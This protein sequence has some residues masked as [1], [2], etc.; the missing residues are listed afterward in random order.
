MPLGGTFTAFASTTPGLETILAGELAAIGAVPG[1]AEPGGIEFDA[2]PSLLARAL[3]SLRTAHRITVR[4]AT[5]HARTF[6]ELERHAATVPWTEFVAKGGAVHFRVTSKK[7]KLY[8]QD[9]IAERLERAALSASSGVTAVRAPSSAEAME[10]DL[11]RVPAMQ[12]IVIR[13]MRDAVTLSA[14][15]SGAL[16]HR[17]G[18]RQAVAKAPLRETL[19]AALVIASGWHPEV[20]LLDP[21]CGSGTIAIEAA[22]IARRMVPGRA[23]RFAAERWPG[24]GPIFEIARREALAAELAAASS[25]IIGRDR[26]AGAIDAARSNAERAGVAADVNFGLGALSATPDDAAPGYVVTNPPYGTRIGERAKLRDL[27]ATI[28]QLMRARLPRSSLTMLTADRVLEGHTALAFDELFR[29]T[30][31]GIP[32]HAVR[33]FGR[34]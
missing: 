17:R 30:N 32:V 1:R 11:E 19:A 13:V 21:L 24:F 22:M 7:S 28:G 15:A 9:A 14:D 23:R 27:Y 25:V 16:L 31:G 2:T 34:S 33:A 5:F 10:E 8:H 29:T 18:Y 6:G 4:L 26:D 20:P 12:R 3:L